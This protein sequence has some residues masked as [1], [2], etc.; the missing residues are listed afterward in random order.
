MMRV[1]K[2]S[3]LLSSLL[4]SI[5]AVNLLAGCDTGKEKQERENRRAKQAERFASG[6]Y[7]AKE[8]RISSTETVK[9]VI[10][11]HNIMKYYDVK[12]IV[13]E[14]SA[15]SQTNMVCPDASAGGLTEQ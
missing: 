13:Y 6:P 9:L 10:I 3:R 15:L 5:I 12:C 7:L 4:V 1:N 14:N 11:P 8:S 2:P